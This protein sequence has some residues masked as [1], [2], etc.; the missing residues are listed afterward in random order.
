MKWHNNSLSERIRGAG[1]V[2]TSY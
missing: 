2:T 1:L